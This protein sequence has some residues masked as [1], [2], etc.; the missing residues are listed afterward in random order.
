ME[1]YYTP[2]SK[3]IF[4]EVKTKAIELWIH[5]YSNSLG[6]YL[7]EK[8]DRIDNLEN[9]QDN[10]M[11]IV[12][13]FDLPNQKLLARELSKEAKQAIHDRLNSQ[14]YLDSIFI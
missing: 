9:V 10:M 14:T 8:L 6:G 12:A 1:L 3:E 11:Y 2:P 4:E 7:E 5:K 13:M